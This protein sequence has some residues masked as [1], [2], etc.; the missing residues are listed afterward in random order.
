MR[1]FIRNKYLKKNFKPIN[2]TSSDK[3]FD[4]IEKTINDIS[5]L[6]IKKDYAIFEFDSKINETIINL[7]N[8]IDD[9]SAKYI[10][11]KE[12]KVSLPVLNVYM[13]KLNKISEDYPIDAPA[14]T[15]NISKRDIANCE[16]VALAAFG[17]SCVTLPSCAAGGLAFMLKI[18]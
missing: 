16:A 14:D 5:L 1:F 17:V 11:K 8:I 3:I 9:E 2:N 18:K 15:E 6:K 4:S 10:S 13:D 7:L 12:V